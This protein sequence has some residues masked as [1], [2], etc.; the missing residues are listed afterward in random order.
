MSFSCCYLLCLAFLLLHLAP[1]AWG[2]LNL[3]VD[4]MSLTR[5]WF[6][7]NRFVFEWLFNNWQLQFDRAQCRA[8]ISSEFIYSGSSFSDLSTSIQSFSGEEYTFRCHICNI[9]FKRVGGGSPSINWEGD[10]APTLSLPRVV[11]QLQFFQR[12]PSC[13][14]S[15]QLGTSKCPFRTS[16]CLCFVNIYSA[17]F[18]A[19]G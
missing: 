6:A 1:G 18:L 15:V 7:N 10:F 4:F 13:T 16:N 19:V 12:N 9:P 8:T 17:P 11:Y 5:D 2:S 3:A 14:A